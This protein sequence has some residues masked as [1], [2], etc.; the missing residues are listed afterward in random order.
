[1]NLSPLHCP[2]CRRI[3]RGEFD[4]LWMMRPEAGF[5]CVVF[6]PLNPVTPGHRLVVPM[7][8]VTDAGQE[9]ILTGVAFECAAVIATMYGRS[10]NLITSTGSDATQT[11]PHLHVHLVPRRPDDGLALP[12]TGQHREDVPA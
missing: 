7:R 6:E 9:P 5:G 1:M 2:F 4:E 3:E 11:V 10:F 12:W 8:H